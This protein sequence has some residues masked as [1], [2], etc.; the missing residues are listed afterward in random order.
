MIAE[1]KRI[2][3]VAQDV[4]P[5]VGCQSSRGNSRDSYTRLVAYPATSSGCDDPRS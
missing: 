3:L 1:N 5:G 2:A 4:M